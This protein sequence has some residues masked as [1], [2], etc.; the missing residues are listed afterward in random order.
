ME[1]IPLEVVAPN[2]GWLGT[3]HSKN[4]ILKFADQNTRGEDIQL[5]ITKVRLNRKD[6]DILGKGGKLLE[7][8][9]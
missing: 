5:P 6:R 1:H 4:M 2:S 3:L 8:L 7:L 9:R